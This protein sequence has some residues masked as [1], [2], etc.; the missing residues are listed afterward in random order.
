MSPPLYRFQNGGYSE[1]K[2]FAP[3]GS[4]FFPFRLPPMINKEDMLYVK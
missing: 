1:S 4:K 3:S 2:E